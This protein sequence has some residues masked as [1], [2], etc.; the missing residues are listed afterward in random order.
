MDNTSF[1]H[2]EHISQMCANTGVKLMFLPLHSRD[3][4]TNKNCLAKLK[5]LFRST[6]GYYADDPD[7]KFGYIL[8][9]CIDQAR[10]RGQSAR[11]HFPHAVLSIEDLNFDI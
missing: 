1:Y 11:G 7:H 8:E 3:L 6:W 10:A 9:Q 4:N 2:S 5:G